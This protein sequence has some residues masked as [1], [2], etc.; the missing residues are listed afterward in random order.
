MTFEKM[1]LFAD[2]GEPRAGHGCAQHQREHDLSWPPLLMPALAAR[3]L[4]AH[5]GLPGYG[6][7]NLLR[8]LT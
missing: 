4:A 2:C 1:S 5:C 7:Q 6:G 3:E 8:L